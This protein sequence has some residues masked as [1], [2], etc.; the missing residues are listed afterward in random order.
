LNSS[1]SKTLLLLLKAECHFQCHKA[2]A[3]P[4]NQALSLNHSLPSNFSGSFVFLKK[5]DGNSSVFFILFPL[6]LKTCR[7]HSNESVEVSNSQSK[8]ESLN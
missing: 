6:R 4:A 1:K 5:A 8:Q 3:N 7:R 2:E